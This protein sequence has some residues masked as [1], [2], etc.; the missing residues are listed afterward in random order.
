[1]VDRLTVTDVDR[2]RAAR[3]AESVGAECADSPELLVN[4]GV[5]ALVIAAATPA[6]ARLLHMAAEARLPAFCEKPIAL[7]GE[8]AR[9]LRSIGG[10]IH[11]MAAF[12]VRFHPQWLRARE[13]VRSGRIG[14]L[15][16]IQVFF[17][18]Q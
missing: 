3:V 10:N 16:A 5:D 6:H 14:E 12:M 4:A 13:L 9:Q 17:S 18:L 11:V 15:R 7:T 2:E 8:E 1:M